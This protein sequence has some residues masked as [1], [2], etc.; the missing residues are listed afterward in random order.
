MS[1]SPSG[2]TVESRTVRPDQ[3]HLNDGVFQKAPTKAGPSAVRK[4]CA[5]AC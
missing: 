1:E 2:E 3:H 5:P 4:H